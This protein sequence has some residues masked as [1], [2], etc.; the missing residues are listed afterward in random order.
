MTQNS[1]NFPD[2]GFILEKHT[3]ALDNCLDNSYI[4]RMFW[5]D[6][7]LTNVFQYYIICNVGLP[8]NSEAFKRSVTYLH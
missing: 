8:W 4:F 1:V 6:L 7:V 5:L 2:G 3:L